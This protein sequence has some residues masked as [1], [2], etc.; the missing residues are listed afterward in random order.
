MKNDEGMIVGGL[1]SKNVGCSSCLYR[2]LCV[3]YV[4]EMIMKN[5]KRRKLRV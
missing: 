1:P 4:N 5:K 3:K 2:V